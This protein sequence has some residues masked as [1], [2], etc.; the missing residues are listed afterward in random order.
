MCFSELAS[1]TT[2]LIKPGAGWYSLFT[3]LSF[4]SS[5]LL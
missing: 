3:L 4:L 1:D 2:L 5:L